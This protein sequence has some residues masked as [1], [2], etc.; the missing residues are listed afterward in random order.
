M[1]LLIT[2]AETTGVTEND[3]IVEVGAVVYD[4]AHRC[5]VDCF[6]GLIH[7]PANPAEFVNGIPEKLLRSMNIKNRDQAFARLAD[8]ALSCDA[9]GAHNA[10]F[11]KG[12]VRREAPPLDVAIPW[13]CT[14]EDFEWPKESPAKNLITVALSHG[15][16]V[17]SAHRAIH[18]CLLMARVF[19]TIEDID[20]RMKKALNHAMLPKFRFVSLAP[21]EEK[22]TVKANGFSWD[23]AARQWWRVMAESDAEALP[24]SVRRAT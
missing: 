21:F 20:E 14:I 15:V 12:F 4:T 10:E 5:M 17:T 24:F 8:M 18:D 23:A 2:D 7:A 11:D 1:R 3:T 16:A 22:D 6:S 19:D 13:I 9:F